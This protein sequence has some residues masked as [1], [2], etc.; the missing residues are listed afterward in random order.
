MQDHD[1]SITATSWMKFHLGYSRNKETG[2]ADS[3][4][5]LY[6]GGLYPD[7]SF[8]PS[9]AA[10]HSVSELSLLRD[11]RRDWNEYRFGGDIDFAGFR[12]SILRQLSYFKDDSP[13]ASLIPGQPYPVTNSSVATAYQRG[14][15]MH[16]HS[17][18]WFANL[19]TT[20]KFWSI[21]SRV[22]YTE[23][24]STFIYQ[25]SGT[26]AVPTAATGNVSTFYSGAARGPTVS[27]DLSFSFFPDRQPEYRQ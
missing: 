2:P 26:G 4:Y 7:P 22:S 1:L 15:P 12:L 25:E 17:P 27:G 5:E 21:N 11:T 6:I 10:T 9:P 23:S 18:T 16:V 8:R 24:D 3:S 20:R 14:Q 19:T 13:I